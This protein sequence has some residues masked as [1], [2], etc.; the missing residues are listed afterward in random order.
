MA[1]T[2]RPSAAAWVKQGLALGHLLA[3]VVEEHL[4]GV[5]GRP[6]RP[7]RRSPGGRSLRSP[8]RGHAR[9][10]SR[11]RAR[12]DWRARL[13]PGG[14]TAG[15]RRTAGSPV[16]G[17]IA[18]GRAEWPGRS[19]RA[20]PAPAPVAAG[21]DARQA[22]LRRPAIVGIHGR[23]GRPVRSRPVRRSSGACRAGGRVLGRRL[24]E[25]GRADADDGRGGDP[26][27]SVSIHGEFAPE[28]RIDS[29]STSPHAREVDRSGPTTG[30]GSWH[31]RSIRPRRLEADQQSERW[32]CRP[33]NLCRRGRS[34]FERSGPATVARSRAFAGIDPVGR[35]RPCRRGRL[36]YDDSVWPG[37]SPRPRI[38]RTTGSQIYVPIRV[39]SPRGVR[40]PGNRGPGRRRPGALARAHAPGR[41][42]GQDRRRAPRAEPHGQAHHRR[43]DGQE[44][45][46]DLPQGPRPPEVLLPQG[47][48]RRV[49]AP[50]HHA[51]REDPRGQPRLR[52]ARLRPLPQAVRR[53]AGDGPG[54]PQ[55]EARLHR[56]RVDGR[57]P[58]Q[59]RLPQGRRRGPR[60]DAEADQ[61]R[62]P[63]GQGRRREGRR[64][65]QEA[66]DPATATGTGWSTSSTPPTSSNSTSAA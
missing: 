22:G 50:G 32:P 16:S 26:G 55:G 10:A 9:S 15:W 41:E 3:G 62:T 45:V 51:R 44:V 21:G 63:P 34:K 59:A 14:T 38:L 12:R 35:R 31:T 28:D 46:Q 6:R 24:G 57:R 29:G 23:R 8:S 43:R 11:R 66:R 42:D 47:R 4:R 58:R 52:Q 2:L 20:G 18:R 33:S 27:E 61:A 56:R 19:R 64:G 5:I 13:A 17:R 48:R 1:S 54:D 25:R 53:A 30:S 37:G 36:D 40:A 39:P 7:A 49:P 65:R 60:P